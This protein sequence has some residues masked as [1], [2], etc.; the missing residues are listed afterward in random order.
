MRSFRRYWKLLLAS[1]PVPEPNRQFQEIIRRRWYLPMYL[2]SRARAP[3]VEH[4][5][6]GVQ[7]FCLFVGFPRSGHRLYEALLDAHPNIVIAH[8]LDALGLFDAGFSDSQ[9]CY[10]VLR[11]S[12]AFAQRGR[13]WSG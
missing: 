5:L 10:L 3:E 1:H 6:S 2:R 7:S 12:E 9:V 8:E 4:L 11:N 13:G